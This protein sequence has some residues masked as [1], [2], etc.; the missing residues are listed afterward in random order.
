VMKSGTNQ[1][2][3]IGPLCFLCF[4]NE[5]VLILKRSGVTAKLFADDVKMYVSI[6]KECDSKR[7]QLAL[8]QLDRWARAWQLSISVNK[9]FVISLGTAKSVPLSSYHLDSFELPIVKEC[10]DL[11]IHITS[12]LSVENHINVVSVKANQRAKLILRCFTSKNVELLLRAYKVY[13]RPLLEYNCV[14]WSPSLIKHIDQIE[15]VQRRFTKYLPGFYDVP[16][17]SRLRLLKLE[18]LEERRIRFDLIFCYKIVFGLVKTDFNNLFSDFVSTG[19]RGHR[20]RI[21]RERCFKTVRRNF[22]AYRVLNYWNNLPVDTDFGSLRSFK[23]YISR[24]DLSCYLRYT[25]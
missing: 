24:L 17:E 5:L 3:V 23:R 13:V 20:F 18:T 8:D 21:Y 7:L 25:R 15:R 9:C 10:K 12:N 14:A 6:E 22:F 16:Y 1:G 11:G 2:S 4:I 19:T